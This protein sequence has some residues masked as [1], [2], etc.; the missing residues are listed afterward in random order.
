LEACLVAEDYGQMS[1]Q[2]REICRSAPQL[3]ELTI[4]A[5][6]VAKSEF[7]PQKVFAELSALLANLD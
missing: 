3:E 7:S 2:L 1:T 6:E 5:E 4:A